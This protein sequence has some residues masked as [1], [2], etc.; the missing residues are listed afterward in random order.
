M[1]SSH[2]EV[3]CVVRDH[4]AWI[5]MNRPSVMN[6][7]SQGMFLM[8]TRLL[9]RAEGDSHARLIVITGNGRAFSAGLDIKEVSGFVSP[10]E[11]RHFVYDLVKPFWETLFSCTKPL[12]SMVNGPA[13]GAGAEIALASDMVTASKD[14]TFAFSGGRVGALCCISGVIGPMVLGAR[15]IVE[16]N[17]TGE[18]ISAVEAQKIGLVNY[19]VPAHELWPTTEKLL[20][21]TLKVS[22]VSSSSFKRILRATVSTRSIQEAYKQLLNTITSPDFRKGAA[23][24][25]KKQ[26]PNYWT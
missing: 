6:A 26:S 15:K 19:V 10:R 17:L 18:P 2:G 7:L 8:L 4:V 24:F 23:A 14:S 13:Y 22:P 21:K 11:A 5:S 9:K 3:E 12:V 1:K 25:A 16:M 20:A